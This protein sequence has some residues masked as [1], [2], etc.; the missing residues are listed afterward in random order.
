[1]TL[2]LDRLSCY[3]QQK[4]LIDIDI[5][6][7]KGRLAKVEINEHL[8]TGISQKYR[9]VLTNQDDLP[10]VLIVVAG[11]YA[12]F[13]VDVQGEKVSTGIVLAN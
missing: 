2:D 10:D 5:D 6:E 9:V 13:A 3:G 7:A 12:E 11:S 1:M 4:I 8:Y